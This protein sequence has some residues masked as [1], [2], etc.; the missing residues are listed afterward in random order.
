MA[1][2]DQRGPQDRGSMSSGTERDGMSRNVN[3]DRQ[4]GMDR[5]S[6]GQASEGDRSERSSETVRE[7]QGGQV[8]RAGN[9]KEPSRDSSQRQRD[10]GDL[11]D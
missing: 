9:E 2:N 10:S 1:Q 7:R 11:A 3:P 8:G 4:S 5:D 6:G